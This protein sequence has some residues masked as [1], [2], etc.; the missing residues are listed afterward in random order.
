MPIR[1]LSRFALSAC[2]ATVTLAGCGGA[3]LPIGA[4]GTVPHS[5][6]TSAPRA[7]RSPRSPTYKVVF[8]FDGT[9]GSAPDGNLLDVN[10]AL[11]GTTSNGGPSD[12][13]NAFKLSLA[14]EQKILHSFSGSDGANP[15]GSLI[16]VNGTLY[17][18]TFDGGDYNLGVVF[19]M[20]KSGTEKVLHSF[21][22]SGDGWN[23][24]PL[25]IANGTLYGTTN[26]GGDR[27]GKGTD[28]SIS[29]TGKEEVLYS[30]SDSFDGWFPTPGLVYAHGQLYGTTGA[31]GTN[32]YGN[33]GSVEGRSVPPAPGAREL[34]HER[35]VVPLCASGCY[36]DYG[37]VFRVSRTGAE[38][39][40]FTFGGYSYGADPAAGLTLAR[41]KLYGTTSFGGTYNYGSGSIGGT[42]FTIKLD[43]SDEMMLH[44]FGYAPDGSNPEAPLLY[45]GGK[46]YGTTSGGGA[47]GNGTVFRMSLDGHEKVLHSFGYGSDGATPVGGLIDVSG[48][49]YGTTS[50][51][52]TY[53]DGTV[54]ELKPQ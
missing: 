20:S 48:T 13:G 9:D 7:P 52:G 21:G 38:K 19:S 25:I 39:V 42:A 29:L 37:T 16:R 1:E 11:Y 15:V 43:G 41:G 46:L 33:A 49:L 54:F 47:Y 8:S 12:D 14:G 2:V 10:G 44:S 18:A 26:A 22:N 27:G 30:F 34:I 24:W 40:L 50:A 6:V 3:Q 5:V 28:F 32:H 31:G 17:G 51:G 4:P 35:G 23:P 45:V 36:P 53:G